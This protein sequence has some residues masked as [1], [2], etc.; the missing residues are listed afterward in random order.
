MWFFMKIQYCKKSQT[1][2]TKGRALDRSTDFCAEEVEFLDGP[3]KIDGSVEDTSDLD[4][5]EQEATQ[6]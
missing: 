6:Q 3:N 5:D 1:D 2:K 4:G